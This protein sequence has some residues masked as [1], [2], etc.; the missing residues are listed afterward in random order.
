MKRRLV[1]LLLSLGLC[2]PAQAFLTGLEGIIAQL[3]IPLVST[4]IE[5]VASTLLLSTDIVTG[6][7]PV[8][9]FI[10]DNEAQLAY[11]LARGEGEYLDALADLM[12]MPIEQRTNWMLE[13]QQTWLENLPEDGAQMGLGFLQN[14][15]PG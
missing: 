9:Q 14:L 3:A 2:S 1:I 5:G 15:G 10:E 8:V 7:L 11:N 12:A 6:V 4:A 13:L